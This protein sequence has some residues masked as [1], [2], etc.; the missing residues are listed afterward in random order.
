MVKVFSLKLD[1]TLNESCYQYLINKASR[2]KRKKVLAYFRKQDAYRSLFADYLARYA[3]MQSSALHNAQIQFTYNNY[4]KPLLAG[5][6]D[7]HFNISHAGEWVV[8]AVSDAPVGIDIEW[9][10]PIDLCTAQMYF[11]TEEYNHLFRQEQEAQLSCFYELWTLKES[12]M[13]QS[14]KGLSIPPGSFS[15]NVRSKENITLNA[16]SETTGG[17]FFKL[18]DIDLSYKMAICTAA[19]FT[20]H[21]RLISL[22]EIMR[23]ASSM[24]SEYP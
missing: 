20:G 18:Y 14:G 6:D 17:L 21:V 3:I 22:H 24:L 23:S 10:E 19:P 5:V 15:I 8:C 7:V 2:D 9:I 13:K 1:E 11:S 16:G 12:Y 4:G